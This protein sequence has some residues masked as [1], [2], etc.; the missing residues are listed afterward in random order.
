MN[1]SIRRN[2][3]ALLAL[4]AV[5]ALSFLVAVPAAHAAPKSFCYDTTGGATTSLAYLTPGTATTTL[6]TSNC[7][8]RSTALNDLTLAIEYTASSTAPKLN[9]RLEGSLD[10]IDWFG[11]AVPL[12]TS[13]TTGTTTSITGNFS[14]FQTILA[15]STTDTGPS[16]SLSRVHMAFKLPIIMPYERVR[17][18]VPSGGGNGALWAALI[19][20]R[21]I[22]GR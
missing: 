6:T 3:L 10:G 17:F 21:E 13:G 16:G 12:I 2:S 1:I 5:A 18:Y 7:F 11:L 4:A 22:G 8:D 19:G 15:T 20:Q 14:D 9:M